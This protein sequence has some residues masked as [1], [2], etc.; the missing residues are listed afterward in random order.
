MVRFMPGGIGLVWKLRRL[1][2]S[3]RLVASYIRQIVIAAEMNAAHVCLQIILR[4][5]A[6]GQ[7]QPVSARTM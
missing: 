6:S 4:P 2:T 1:S 5:L 3:W 7:V